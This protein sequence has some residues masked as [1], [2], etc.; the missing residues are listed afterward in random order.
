MIPIS[1]RG[2]TLKTKRPTICSS[3]TAPI[4]VFRESIDTSRLS[5]ITKIRSSG[6]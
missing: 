1:E 4:E 3:E 5:P 2:Q 6:T